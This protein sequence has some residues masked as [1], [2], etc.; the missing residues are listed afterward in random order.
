MTL[1]VNGLGD[2]PIRRP[3]S[4]ST[5]VANSADANFFYANTPC[6]LMYHANYPNRVN[7]VSGTGIWLMA[8]KVKYSAQDLYGTVPVESGGTGCTTMDDF[9][10]EITNNSNFG[11]YIDVA[12]K[13]W[14]T[15]NFAPVIAYGT[16]EVTAGSSSTY[17]E[18]TLY[19]VIE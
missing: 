18:G 7:G 15:V 16:D 3:L 13:D 2:K 8:D 11:G 4:F 17:P 1:N 9:V 14:A 5:Y 6:R 19:V 10:T 12:V